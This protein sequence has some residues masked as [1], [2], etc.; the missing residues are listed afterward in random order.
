MSHSHTLTAQDF[1]LQ[2]CRSSKLRAA[3]Q[4]QVQRTWAVQQEYKVADE[5]ESN[6]K[7]YLYTGGMA[8]MMLLCFLLTATVTA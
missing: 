6:M 2:N 1:Y 3:L 4:P 5:A 8:V 7:F